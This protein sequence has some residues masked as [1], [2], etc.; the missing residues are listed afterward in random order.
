[1]RGRIILVLL[2]I[3]GPEMRGEMTII[4]QV[5]F[6]LFPALSAE[7]RGQLRQPVELHRR[8]RQVFAGYPV[9]RDATSLTLRMLQEA[10]E[11]IIT[12]P[13]EEISRL[14]FPGEM[15]MD[16]VRQLI[17][18]DRPEEALSF[19]EPLLA[20]RSQLLDLMPPE[21]RLPFA[22]LP[23][24]AL[25]VGDPGR[26]IA[27]T[28]DLR[29]LLADFDSVMVDFNGYEL[30]GFHALGLAEE[31]AARLDDW[32]AAKGRF[33]DSALGD[34]IAASIALDEGR[35]EE[36]LRRALRPIVFSGQV[37]VEHLDA[38]Y[39]M[40]VVCAH[41]MENPVH[42]DKLL[43]EMQERGLPWRSLSSF[44]VRERELA[45][46]TIDL[47]D[48]PQPAFQAV[49]PERNRLL[50]QEN[51]VAPP[52]DFDPAGILSPASEPEI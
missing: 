18:E 33:A 12:F 51:T 26:A 10:G 30:V 1:M 31:A 42:R 9:S 48:G 43:E 28:R 49:S 40:A 19:L 23:G 46:L 16:R 3:L 2:L 29:P 44:A 39:S 14:V 22:R 38:C 45:G 24:L 27:F 7:E 47:G 17:K 4:E 21:A 11:V 50:E 41:L 36:A 20:Q 52:V 34:Y 6:G 37:S 15:L 32:F 13:Y 35:I 5:D 25:A 8:D